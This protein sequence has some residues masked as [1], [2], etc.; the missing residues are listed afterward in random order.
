MSP[1]RIE[2]KLDYGPFVHQSQK[3]RGG[4]G[5]IATVGDLFMKVSTLAM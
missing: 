4:A 5:D 1:P 3:K 2:S